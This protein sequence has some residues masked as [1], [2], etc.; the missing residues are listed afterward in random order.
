[1]KKLFRFLIILIVITLVI[2]G[3]FLYIQKNYK[4]EIYL[5]YRDNVLKV[6]EN[7][8]INKN[9]YFKNKNYKYVQNTND[10]VA[11]DKNH[12]LNIFYTII[13]S[14]VDSFTFYCDDSYTNCKQDIVSLID[15]KDTLSSINN[16]VHPYN[17]FEKVSTT[18]DDYGQ[19]DIKVE[20]VYSQDDIVL[21]NKKVDEIINKEIK[22]NMNNK[23]KIEAIHNYIINHG[24]YATDK[25]REKNKDKQYNKANDILLDGYGLCSS[26]ADA[27]AI[28]LHRFGIDN[29]KIASSSHIWNLVNIDNKWL[30]LDLTWDD[31]V[32]EDRSKDTLLH[33]FFLINTRTLESFDIKDHSY[34]KSIY[35]E[36]N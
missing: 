30:H 2:G 35:R 32:S 27:M 17:S 25:I 21:I 1:M 10:F 5:Y 14:G 22:N 33:K 26:Y 20:K 29:Y 7:I 4:D 31:P 3:A 15:N 34:N 12:L 24:K 11:K 23:Q 18:Y 16:F 6:R 36:L 19:I 9:E 13:N 8:K 28:F